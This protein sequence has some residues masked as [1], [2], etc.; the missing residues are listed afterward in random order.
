MDHISRLLDW[1]RCDNPTSMADTNVM[2]S[3][4]KSVLRILQVNTLDRCTPLHS[5]LFH[6][7]RL[8]N[9]VLVSQSSTHLSIKNPNN[10]RDYFIA[11]GTIY[12]T[13]LLYSQLRTYFQYGL[14]HRAHLT[15][16]SDS[17]LKITIP[18][19]P[20][21]AKS[22]L[23]I[24]W[25]PGQHIFIR[26]VHFGPHALTS[27]PFTICSLPPSHSTNRIEKVEDAEMVLYIKPMKGITSKLA[28][29]ALQTPNTSIPIT[30][31]GPYGGLTIST[32]AKFDSVLLN[33]GGSGTGFT[34]PLVEDILWHQHGSNNDVFQRKTK[35]YVVI[36]TRSQELKVWF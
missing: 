26:F 21:G 14:T 17:M 34:L 19:Y 1:R 33:A 18:I 27:R 12:S 22:P 11:T 20:T 10:Q 32:F 29:L 36:A 15:L 7:L 35:I 3:N 4:T 30:L 5:L 24:S 31:D 6:P 9:V 8:Q 25:T 13:T 16:L 23:T 28:S 2:E